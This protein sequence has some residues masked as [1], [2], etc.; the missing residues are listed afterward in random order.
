MSN[1]H[2]TF[3]LIIIFDS[4]FAI[5]FSLSV[6]TRSARDHGLPKSP[7]WWKSDRPWPWY[8]RSKTTT[9]SST[10]LCGTAWLTTA[11]G[12]PFNSWTRRVAW[13]AASSCPDSPRSRTSVPAHPFCRM[14]TSRR[15]SSQTRWKY[16]SS[17]PYRYVG[18]SAQINV[19]TPTPYSALS[20]VI[21]YLPTIRLWDQQSTVHH[22]RP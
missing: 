3:I 15:S 19:R 4:F 11:N 7:G 6:L 22:P 20:M 12:H 10:C 8:W 21:C 1:V 2:Y 18:T 17:A 14:H 16:T 13:L 5:Y 9:P